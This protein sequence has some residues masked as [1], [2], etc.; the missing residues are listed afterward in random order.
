[1]Y[2]HKIHKNTYYIY[3][4]TYLYMYISSTYIY[5]YIDTVEILY[6]SSRQTTYL[7]PWAPSNCTGAP[8]RGS[9]DDP[10]HC[11]VS[12]AWRLRG[13]RGAVG[14]NQANVG[15]RWIIYCIYIYMCVRH[16]DGHI[17]IYCINNKYWYIYIY[18]YIYICTCKEKKHMSKP[19][20]TEPSGTPH[21][22]ERPLGRGPSRDRTLRSCWLPG[23]R[24]KNK[25]KHFW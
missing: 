6:R 17:Y 7:R 10:R 25:T 20:S 2:V 15:I 3:I 24:K 8:E 11:G 16:I 21:W 4:Y 1:M 22:E 23:Y 18:M 14:I 9:I 19:Y 5:I 13:A 12:V